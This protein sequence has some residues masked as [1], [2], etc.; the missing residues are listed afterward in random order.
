MRVLANENIPAAVVNALVSHGHDVK[1]IR[2]A[3]PGASDSAILE[4]ARRETRLIVTFDK[5]FG[6]LAFRSGLPAPCGIILLRIPTASPEYLAE[7]VLT[8][9]ESR[10]DWS[11]Y[12]SVVLPDRI[13]M[14]ALNP[15]S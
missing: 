3:A 4:I 12:F 14:T 5:D 2:T 6:E 7:R 13:K 11:G 9:L 1:W 10:S 8:S 15:G